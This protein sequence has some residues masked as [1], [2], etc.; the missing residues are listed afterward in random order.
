[1]VLSAK[2]LEDRRGHLLIRFYLI[3]VNLN[4]HIYGTVPFLLACF[5]SSSA[6]QPENDYFL[7]S[8]NLTVMVG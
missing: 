8:Y 1:M 6:P 5:Q 7:N 4:L 2:M 3:F